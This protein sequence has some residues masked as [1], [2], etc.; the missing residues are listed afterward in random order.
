MKQPALFIASSLIL[1]L[2]VFAAA[3]PSHGLLVDHPLAALGMLL[4]GVGLTKMHRE[5]TH[6]STQRVAVRADASI[7]Q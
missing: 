6:E 3:S 2:V 5:Q 4:I 7:K 1:L